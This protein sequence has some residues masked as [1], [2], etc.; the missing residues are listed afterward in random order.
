MDVIYRWLLPYQVMHVIQM[1]LG[2]LTTRM[3]C[4]V[5]MGELV[6]MPPWGFP[7]LGQVAL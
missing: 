5:Q 2:M 3:F 7:L 1:L 4:A 6:G